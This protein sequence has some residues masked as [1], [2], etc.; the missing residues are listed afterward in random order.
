M[1]LPDT[2]AQSAV[3]I[4]GDLIMDGE[5]VRDLLYAFDLLTLNGEDLRS[6][7][8]KGRYL[9]L[10]NLMAAYKSDHLVHHIQFA[11]CAS[12]TSDKARLLAELKSKQKEGVV[13]KRL[14]APYI[15]GR[16]NSG[17]S[18]LKHKFYAIVS[19]VVTKI[20]AQ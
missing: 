5:A 3:R 1:G 19:A 8:Y 14:D 11:P 13:F 10:M 15:A 4:L 16:P 20:N 7:P 2:I 17:G 9:A 12:K 6:L 18:Q